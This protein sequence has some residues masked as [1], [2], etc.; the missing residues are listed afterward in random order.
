MP[1][2]DLVKPAIP[3]DGI[4]ILDKKNY[5]DLISIQEKGAAKG[6]F[7]KFVPASGAATRM[8]KALNSCLLH[9]KISDLNDLSN[10]AETDNDAKM[11][12]RFIKNIDSFAFYYELNS[13]AEEKNVNIK[14]LLGEGDFKPVLQLLLGPEGLNLD[15][16]PKGLIKF[17][18]YGRDAKTPLYEHFLEAV[19]YAADESKNAK[20][21]FTVPEK[22][23]EKIRHHIGRI[24]K[25]F[26]NYHFE[27]ELSHQELSTQT[28]AVDS[29]N[30]PFVDANGRLL[31]RPGGH[32]ALIHNLNRIDADFIYIKNIDN[33]TPEKQNRDT[34]L[35]KKI[36]GGMLIMLHEK[37]FD[38]LNKL[39][40]GKAD[41]ETVRLA[42]RF[43]REELFI[44]FPDNFEE[45]TY[46]TKVSTLIEKLNRPLRV[47]G[48]VENKGEPGG[49]PF[50]VRRGT[51][52][53][54][55]II[56]KAQIDMSNPEQAKA[57]AASTHFNPV[58]LVCA[59]RDYRGRKFDLTQ[60]IDED[61]AFI[62]KKSK[63][64]R[65]LKALEHPGLW[66]GAMAD[67]N[68][69][70]VEVPI[71]TFNP[72]KTVNDLLREKHRG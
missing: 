35:H 18:G 39:S 57:L 19:E 53:S 59:V 10:L 29:E 70:F 54:L 65:E 2:A 36:L 4:M 56:E 24:T 34:I 9:N 62:T 17:H 72:V 38:Y 52:L 51:G 50:W 7:N 48:M 31:I 63:G 66:N 1:F 42:A 68:T 16:M 55:Q 23:D 47:C 67:W 14:T 25:Y 37:A 64:G 26:Q 8:F 61:M 30:N 15:D 32:G 44:S 20:L 13:I 3:G 43:A 27:V 21:H 69:V 60:F 49:G 28:L 58:D 22:Y 71:S 40:S 11:T 6:R 46:D 12:L 41:E 45:I 33:V 5:A